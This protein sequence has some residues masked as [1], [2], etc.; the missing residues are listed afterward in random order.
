M[1]KNQEKIKKI[2]FIS[3]NTQHQNFGAL[4]ARSSH[5]MEGKNCPG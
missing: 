1:K 5:F 3:K 4:K 2:G